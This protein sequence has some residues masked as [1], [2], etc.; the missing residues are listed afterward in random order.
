MAHMAWGNPRNIPNFRWKT[1]A[2][3]GK[4][5]AG[6]ECAEGERGGTSRPA[7]P[8]DAGADFGHTSAGAGRAS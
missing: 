2:T 3:A 8:P 7:P 1:D 4:E 5:P 6:G